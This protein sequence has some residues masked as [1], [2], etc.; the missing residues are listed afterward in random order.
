[1]VEK[2]LLSIAKTSILQYFDESVRIDE[3]ALCK[4]HPFLSQEGACFVTLHKNK[5]LRG[6]IG[7]LIAHR[8]LLEDIFHNAQAAAFSDPRFAPLEPSE[9]PFLELEVSV[10][11]PPRFLRYEDYDDL[12]QKIQPHKD[13]LIL[14]YGAH[15]GTFLPQV[16]EQLP[17]PKEFLEHLSY[18]A[19]TNPT[20][21]AY[22]P[23]IYT[24]RV[25]AI[26][27]RFDAIQPL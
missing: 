25:E 5:E 2:V 9:F 21:F 22:H 24:Y 7:S 15:Q 8:P 19:G 16:W 20:I 12:V 1:M 4:A 6:C 14:R 18:K 11:T 27:E 26:E 10:L 17:T 13:G 3:G 23:E